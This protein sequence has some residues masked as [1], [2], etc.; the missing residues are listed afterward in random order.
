LSILSTDKDGNTVHNKK[1]ILEEREKVF[2]LDT[3]KAFKLNAGT[4][5]VCE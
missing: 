1:I 3:G 5:G 2:E 4:T